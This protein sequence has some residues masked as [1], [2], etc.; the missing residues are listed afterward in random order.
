MREAWMA[1]AVTLGIVQAASGLNIPAGGEAVSMHLDED[2]YFR[3]GDGR[4]FV[5][6]G[7]LHGNVAPLRHLTVSARQREVWRRNDLIWEARGHAHGQAVDLVDLDETQ[8]RAWFEKL[9]DCG[10]NS[11]R[12]FPRRRVDTELLDQIGRLN[13]AFTED[14]SRVFEIGAEYGLHFQLMLLGEPWRTG[15][16]NAEALERHV[17]P[18]YDKATLDKLTPAQRRFLVERRLAQPPRFFSDADV[19]ACQEAFLREAAD[20]LRGHP[21][22]FAVELY[23]EQGWWKNNTI[24][25]RRQKVFV[26]PAEEADEITWSAVMTRII[27]ERM[28]GMPICLSHPGFGVTAY[29]PRLWVEQADV[30]FYSTHQYV[31]LDG[32]HEQVDFAATTGATAAI[33][34]AISPHAFGEWG[35]LD[36]LVDDRVRRRVHRDAIWLSL[37]AG[38]AGFMQWP[39]ECLEEYRWVRRIVDALP[40][41][42]TPGPAELAVDISAAYAA[43]H[44]PDRYPMLMDGKPLPAFIANRR[45]QAD[46]HYR[47]ILQAY[48]RGLEAGVPVRFT[49][50]DGVEAA[51][52]GAAMSLEAFNATDLAAL[53]RP[54]RADG[55]FQLTWMHDSEARVYIAYLRSRRIE[56]HRGQW[57]GMPNPA[58][59]T[60]RFNLP[61]SAAGEPS[62]RMTLVNLETGA[63]RAE[64]VHA[65]A[66]VEAA[67][68]TTD[69]YVLI[70]SPSDGSFTLAE[71]GR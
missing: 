4:L 52:G 12:L 43:L 51:G 35:W 39:F 20:W 50:R 25:G 69:D 54:L 66:A 60:L 62:W 13:R 34:S 53:P 63:V 45:K 6:L 9:R 31:G 28:P 57:I 30:D 8:L 55:G 71:Q 21:N 3:R 67:R 68:R 29:D 32:T 40:P 58:D 37:L 27:R 41:D 65:D 5:P 42:F 36:P 49:M 10:I 24:D 22:V 70:V 47:V 33:L 23:N 2:G 19:R 14:L 16:S 61:A 18:A 7:G 26:S 59:L 1:L 11:L 46:E 56:E 17:L 38:A 64:D 48:H 15:Y 44:D